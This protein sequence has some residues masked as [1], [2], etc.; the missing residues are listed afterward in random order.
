MIDMLERIDAR[1]SH[2]DWV[3]AFDAMCKRHDLEIEK[4]KLKALGVDTI[5]PVPALEPQKPL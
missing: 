1:L 3:I 5:T 2:E 4:G